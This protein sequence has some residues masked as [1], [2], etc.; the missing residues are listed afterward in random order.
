[1]PRKHNYFGGIIGASPLVTA[2]SLLVEALVVGGGGSGPG[3]HNGVHFS[4]GG[5]G[6]DVTVATGFTVTL[7]TALN[8]EIGSGGAAVGPSTNPGAAGTR[9]LFGTLN[10]SGAGSQPHPSGVVSNGSTT[11]LTSPLITLTEVGTTTTTT[12]YSGEHAG[13]TYFNTMIGGG[14]GGY[15]D[16]Y[17]GAAGRRA[18]QGYLWGVNNTRYAGG[19]GSGG[20]N[21]DSRYFASL[22]GIGGGGDGGPLAGVGNNGGS[23]TVNTGGGGGGANGATN[24]SGAGGSGVVLIW[25][26]QTSYTNY[27]TTGLT[28]TANGSFTNAATSAAGTL[29]TITAHTGSA[30]TITFN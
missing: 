2:P 25:V 16:A 4:G 17:T 3:F 30:G 10:A 7:G 19:G 13:Y 29:L 21:N 6:G 12:N 1:M 8:V 28:V 15:A 14:A 5:N 11:R 23:G 18:G 22:G 27:T 9:S 20:T 26:P 24:N